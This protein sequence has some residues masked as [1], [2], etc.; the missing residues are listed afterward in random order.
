M[1]DWYSELGH[2]I[3]RGYERLDASIQKVSGIV[4]NYP[5]QG[6]PK[7]FGQK[8]LID[9]GV[10]PDLVARTILTTLPFKLT[11]LDN[12]SD[13]IFSSK[14]RWPPLWSPHE[15]QLQ[16]SLNQIVW[17]TDWCPSCQVIVTLC[18]SLLTPVTKFTDS[19][20]LRAIC[21]A[22]IP[23]LLTDR[24]WQSYDNDWLG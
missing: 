20:H 15:S 11:W 13:I 5:S 19:V 24:Y 22:S 12:S 2:L 14:N 1:I 10:D 8:F 3:E 6:G 18:S 21:E 4:A 7:W 17:N 9:K 16:L 23:N